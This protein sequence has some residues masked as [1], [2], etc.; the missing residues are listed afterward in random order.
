MTVQNNLQFG[1]QTR[2]DIFL[3]AARL[4]AQKGYDRVSIREICEAVGVSKPTLYYYFKDKRNLILE[5]FRFTQEL[6]QQLIQ[7]HILSKSDFLEQVRGLLKVRKVFVEQ[8]PDFIRLHLLSNLFPIDPRI[9][10]EMEK[11]FTQMINE[12]VEFLR[13][14]QA[15]GYLAP[16]EDLRLV[17]YSVFGMMNQLA[18][19]ALFLNDCNAMSDEM[20]EKVFQFW[21]RHYFTKNPVS[22]G[23][24]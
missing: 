14:G 17:I 7:K 6:S 3:T 10:E 13:K 11:Y 19:R 9:S 15:Q 4:F 23:S 22:G 2:T 8:Y 12:S 24:E 20:L 5:L 1:S 16:D 18:Y 21:K